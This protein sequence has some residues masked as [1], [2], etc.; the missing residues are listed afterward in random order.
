MIFCDYQYVEEA[1]VSIEPGEV[2]RFQGCR[3][4]PV[5]VK[6]RIERLVRSQIDHSYR[7]IQPQAVS[8]GLALTPRINPGYG[9][10][11]LEEQRI[12]FALLPGDR[13]GVTLTEKYIMRPRKSLPFAIGI[14]EGFTIEKSMGRCRHCG[15]INCPYRLD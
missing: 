10:L 8:K 13:I 2:L 14:G 6:G 15:M 4:S 12:V 5:Q 7:L 11:A 9:D 3:A 1:P